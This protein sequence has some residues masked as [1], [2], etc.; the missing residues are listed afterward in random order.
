MYIDGDEVLI[1]EPGQP[2]KRRSYKYNGDTFHLDYEEL[3]GTVI[4]YRQK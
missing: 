3:G 2:F 4:W 1:G